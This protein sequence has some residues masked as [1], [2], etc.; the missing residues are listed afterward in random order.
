MRVT[1]AKLVI[2]LTDNELAVNKV[3][4]SA[5]GYSPDEGDIR[6]AFAATH[7]FFL[8]LKDY[9]ASKVPAGKH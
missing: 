2:W 8:A 9:R 1:D 3:E 7:D 6:G 5:A 4:I